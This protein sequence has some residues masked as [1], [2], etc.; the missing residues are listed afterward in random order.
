[1]RLSGILLSLFLLCSC[2][3]ARAPVPPGEIPAQ[4]EISAAD[5]KYG[6][7]VM[8]A[9]AQRYPLER[10]DQRVNRVRNVADKLSAASGS[11]GN[12]WHVYVFHDDRIK[13]AAATRG[14]Y[15]FVWSGMLQAADND[16]ELA[17]VLAHEIGHALAGHTSPTASEETSEIIAG[18]AGTAAGTAMSYSGYG[19]AARLVASLVNESMKALIVNPESQRKELEA[20]QIGLFLLA[21]AGYDP[22]KAVD[23]WRRAS[24]DPVLAGDQMTFLSTHPSAGER[25]ENL[26]KMLP[27]ALRRAGK[28]PQAKRSEPAPAGEVWIVTEEWAS[29]YN[30]P[31]ETSSPVIDLP[32]H[33][34]VAV[35]ALNRGWLEIKQPV[36]GFVQGRYLS[37]R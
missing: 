1:M 3:P 10:D 11:G 28:I 37:P 32:R 2:A 21:D 23:F 6:H 24:Y 17:A 8:A 34:E 26:E 36:E 13:N 12:P 5:E 30:T 9:L 7:E 19:G 29:V 16:D 20:D 31:D 35:A 4:G 25:V 18:I 14:N 27:D 33:T 22:Q 15:I